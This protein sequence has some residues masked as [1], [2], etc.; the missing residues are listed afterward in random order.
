MNISYIDEGFDAIVIDDFFTQGELELVQ[1]EAQELTQGGQMQASSRALKSAWDE[2][3]PTH[4]VARRKGIFLETVFKDWR[5]SNLIR[6]SR[7]ALKSNQL[8][9]QL[10]EHNSLF[11]LLFAE[12][13]HSHLLNYYE[14][15]DYYDWHEDSTIFTVLCWF[16]QE[17]KAFTGGDFVIRNHRGLEQV[18]EFKNNRVLIIPS[19]TPHRVTPIVMPTEGA[20]T[21]LGRYSLTVFVATWPAEDN[22]GGGKR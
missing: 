22:Y 4:L 6:V 14:H 9:D 2:R 17:P 20:Y 18:V 10:V 7:L 21:G 13:A 16:C 19:C 3:D 1:A 11:R 5:T 15:G 12:Y 8:R